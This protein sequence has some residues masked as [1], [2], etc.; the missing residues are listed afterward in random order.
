MNYQLV[1]I[2]LALGIIVDIVVAKISV[3]NNIKARIGRLRVH[4]T[5][6]G[7]IAIIV[8]LFIY[9]EIFI[10]FGVGVIVSHTARLKRFV[11]IE[12]AKKR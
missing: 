6:Y 10:S 2:G 4:H 12:R 1:A 7:L 3:E 9:R 11:F 5:I 8:G